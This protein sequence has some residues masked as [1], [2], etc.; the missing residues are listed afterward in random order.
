M[1]K[2]V[3][4]HQLV[5]VTKRGRD[6]TVWGYAIQETAMYLKVE[7]PTDLVAIPWANIDE[8]RAE[9]EEDAPWNQS[10]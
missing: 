4:Q 6:Q 2:T 5:S 9:N 3:K 1:T 7:S 10:T 8:V